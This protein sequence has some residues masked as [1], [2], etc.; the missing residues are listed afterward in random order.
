MDK[1][2][3]KL[4]Q[5]INDE[6]PFF[7]L[8]SLV[9]II[10]TAFL[11]IARIVITILY[12]EGAVPTDVISSF[13]DGKDRDFK[14]L[15]LW[16]ENGFFEMYLPPGSDPN[17]FG[18]FYLYHWYFIFFP[19]YIMPTWLSF[20]IWDMLRLFT[21]IYVAYRFYEITVDKKEGLLFLIFCAIGYAVDMHLNN[22]NWLILFL[23][24]LSYLQLEKDRKWLSGILFT[25]ATFKIYVI[26]FPFI[27]FI[28][29]KIKIKDLIYYVVPFL[30]LIIP[31]VVNPSFFF[32]MYS[33]WTIPV[34]PEEISI[35]NYINVVMKLFEPAQL[36]F[37]SFMIIIFELN[38]NQNIINSEKTKTRVY[39]ITVIGESFVF[40]TYLIFLAILSIV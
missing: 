17:F 20:Y 33:N 28:T 22:S 9:I 18:H 13:I 1:T 16:M 37:I 29:K 32:Q 23:L 25:I 34:H 24:A 19:F 12:P 2:N 8:F 6:K 30:I 14:I 38:F 39:V 10:I 21:T 7:K 40:I 4:D 36:M 31:Y 35:L 27:L 3:F 15:L 11:I 5:L 26:I